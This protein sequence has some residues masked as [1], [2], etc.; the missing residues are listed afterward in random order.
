MKSAEQQLL[1]SIDE[2]LVA[3][4]NDL[5]IPYTKVNQEVTDQVTRNSKILVKMTDK[6][7]RSLDKEQTNLGDSL[8][9]VQTRVLQGIDNW[10]QDQELYLQNLAVKGGEIEAGQP[11]EAALA[12]E[13]TEAGETAYLGTLVLAVKE[14]MRGHIQDGQPTPTNRW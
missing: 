3:Q 6:I 7:L 13:T 11:L 5:I 10:L 1:E 4:D 14:R 12:K 9:A 8:N 2:L